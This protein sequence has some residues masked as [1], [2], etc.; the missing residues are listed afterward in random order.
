MTMLEAIQEKRTR[1][2]PPGWRWEILSR[3]LLTLES[4]SR[5]PGGAVG[6]TSGVPSISAEQMTDQGTF[7]FSVMRYV[8]R[9]YYTEMQR[10]HIRKG[11]ILIV[12]D[13][14]TT[15][16][17]CF[18]DDDF[19]FQEAVVNE[20]VFICRPNPDIVVPRFLFY[21]LWSPPGHYAIRSTFQGAAIGG[22]NQRFADTI[23]VPVAPVEEQ[24]RIAAILN[25]Q[26]AAVARA[27]QAAEERLDAS[28]AL[29]TS[30]LRSFLGLPQET[31]WSQKRL[32]DVATLLPSKSIASSGDAEVLAVT[33]ACLSEAGFLSDGVK[34]A[35]MQSEHV[36]ECVVRR[37]EI[38][39]A[40]SNTPELVGRASMYT[41]YP[42]RVVAT[43]L[44]I[45]IWAAAD[46]MRP[47]F[48]AAYLSFLYQTGFWRDRAGGA[49]GSMKKITRNQLLRL[50]VPVPK[51][52]E[53]DTII[54]QID[55]KMPMARQLCEATREELDLINSIP[56][57]LLGRAFSGEL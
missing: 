32:G 56:A 17:T 6:I 15:G 11:D 57:A 34:R 52:A 43:D 30:L 54:Q 21:W 39:V 37:G 38:L 8:P 29:P 50:V 5:P 46:R 45:R 12:K 47:A 35:R 9:D 4:G 23:K 1:K 33:T 20:H 22:I 13:G 36:E 41:G 55:E 53:Q 16:K 28:L 10:G 40:R 14:A 24:K 18:I 51:T 2:L 42:P 19:P 31:S 7:D 49:S 27:R 44:T 26:L 3:L 48:L 25:E